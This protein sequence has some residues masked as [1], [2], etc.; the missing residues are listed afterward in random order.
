M[1]L[2]RPFRARTF[3]GIQI[4]WNTTHTHTRTQRIQHAV[5]SYNN[6]NLIFKKKEAGK[7]TYISLKYAFKM[8]KFI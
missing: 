6:Q 3:V 1:N 4:P 8:T 5:M 2:T 7:A